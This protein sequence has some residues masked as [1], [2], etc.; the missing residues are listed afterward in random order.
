MLNQ[1]CPLM[2]NLF[3]AS[4]VCELTAAF[5][6]DGRQYTFDVHYDDESKKFVYERLTVS[7]DTRDDVMYLRD[8]LSEEY[9]CVN[10]K[11]AGVMPALSR[12]NRARQDGI[13]DTVTFW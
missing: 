9:E 10:P 13:W 12:D 5:L 4:S 7:S 1:S 8:T 11:L 3:T 6:E 2:S